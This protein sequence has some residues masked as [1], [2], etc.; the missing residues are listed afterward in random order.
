MGSMDGIRA[1]CERTASA[2]TA[3]PARGQKTFVTKVQV[4]V[5]KISAVS[6]SF[7]FIPIKR[8]VARV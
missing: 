6:I 7:E 5:L 1:A 4:V 2:L 8:S 3:R